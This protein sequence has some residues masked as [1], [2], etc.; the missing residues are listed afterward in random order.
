[1]I[2]WMLTGFWHGA[3]WTFIVWGLYYGILLILEKFV[4][5]S[6]MK[7]L[8]KTMQW[9]L[10]AILVIISWVI[11]ASPDL[12]SALAYL[13]SMF[14]MQGNLLLDEQTWWLLSNNFILLALGILFVLPLGENI[15][16][17]LKQNY[18]GA[19][20]LNIFYLAMF[21]LSLAYM[22]GQTYQ[23]FLYVQF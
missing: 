10:T 12:G 9:M 5:G 4:F 20:A 6:M 16:G 21:A 1:M 13:K 15:A 7:K 22:M 2:V 19:I 3:N 18:G 14:F 17:R 11:F 8:P 23:T